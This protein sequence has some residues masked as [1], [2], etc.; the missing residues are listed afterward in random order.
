MLELVDRSGLGRA[1]RLSEPARAVLPIG[2]LAQ[3][4]RRAT[5]A[6]PKAVVRLMHPPLMA[7][8][9]KG[10]RSTGATVAGAAAG[11]KGPLTPTERRAAVIAEQNEQNL[12]SLGEGAA[13]K[14]TGE[15]LAVLL[16]WE[17]DQVMACLAHGMLYKETADR[18]RFSVA[19]V[20][21]LQ[22]KAYER[23]GKHKAVE[24]V[25]AWREAKLST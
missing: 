18:L 12:R 10:S 6:M 22:H 5:H 9:T 3:V 21:K 16:T 15:R 23:L 25:A 17:E 11:G 13:R 14:G 1:G 24:A 2:N 8:N 19:K 7:M 4:P 20:K